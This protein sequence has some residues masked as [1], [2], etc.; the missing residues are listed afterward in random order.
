MRFSSFAVLAR[1]LEGGFAAPY[2]HHLGGLTHQNG[3]RGQH[4]LGKKKEKNVEDDFFH[5]K[6]AE[7]GGKCD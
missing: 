4:L 3:G 1:V 2:G 6:M 5:A 7:R